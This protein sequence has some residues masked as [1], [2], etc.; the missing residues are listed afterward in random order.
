MQ[1]SQLQPM[2]RYW[3][4]ISL[5]LLVDSFDWLCNIAVIVV[6]VVV[7]DNVGR[8]GCVDDIVFVVSF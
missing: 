4:C 3:L 8:G 1:G 5:D 2:M 6:V 7:V